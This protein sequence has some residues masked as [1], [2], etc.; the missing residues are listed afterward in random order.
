[1]WYRIKTQRD[2]RELSFDG[3]REERERFGV[4]NWDDYDLGVTQPPK[5]TQD[6]G[7]CQDAIEKLH[8]QSYLIYEDSAK[9]K[10]QLMTKYAMILDRQEM[11]GVE[12]VDNQQFWGFVS[13]YSEQIPYNE[14]LWFLYDDVLLISRLEYWYSGERKPFRSLTQV[15]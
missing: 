14:E 6:N 13:T 11:Y 5:L 7:D 4:F 1:M 3:D 2:Q 12:L 8:E 15:E 9:I 10:K